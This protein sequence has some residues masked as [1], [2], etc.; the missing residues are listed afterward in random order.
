MRMCL[1]F[2]MSR[3]RLLQ[4]FDSEELTYW[5]G[6]QRAFDL[7]DNY[8]LAATTGMAVF[9]SQVSNC[10]AKAGDFAAIYDTPSRMPSP[11]EVLANFKAH[12]AFQASKKA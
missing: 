2:R 8:Y 10:T 1:Q 11:E 6:V 12:A 9:H 4:E 5:L 3:R 7:P